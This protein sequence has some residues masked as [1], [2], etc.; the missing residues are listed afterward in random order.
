MKENESTYAFLCGMLAAVLNTAS[1]YLK[2]NQPQKALE[3]IKIG[4]DEHNKR[5][6]E[7]IEKDLY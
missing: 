5:I 7:I 2:V 3:A 1:E 6:D 4:L